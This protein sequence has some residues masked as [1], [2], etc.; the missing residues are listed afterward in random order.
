MKSFAVWSL[1]GVAG[2]SI[3]QAQ[4]MSIGSWQASHPAG[5]LHLV[6]NTSSNSSSNTSSNSSGGRSSYVHTHSWSV[7]SD[8]GRR[9]RSTRETIR[10]ERYTPNNRRYYLQR[11][12]RDDD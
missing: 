9:R 5:L 12:Q 2:V 8:D 7:D 4:A 6:G 1:A 10:I 11:R 3:C